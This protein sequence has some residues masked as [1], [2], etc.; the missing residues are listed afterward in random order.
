MAARAWKR[1]QGENEERE[2]GERVREKNRIEKSG[3]T[4]EKRRC[5]TRSAYK[6][7]EDSDCTFSLSP[8]APFIKSGMAT[9]MNWALHSV[10]T[11]FASNVLPSERREKREERRV[12]ARIEPE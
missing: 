11:A 5:Y 1:R 7:R 6:R 4:E 12:L 2:E 10:A 3:D 8:T 9:D